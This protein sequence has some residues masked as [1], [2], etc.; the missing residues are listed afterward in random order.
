MRVSDF[1]IDSTSDRNDN[2]GNYKE[3]RD[4]LIPSIVEPDEDSK[5]YRKNWGRLIQKIYE[6][7][8]KT[9]KHLGLVLHALE[10]K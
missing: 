7:I 9:P 6:A 4:A 8:E 3:N 1:Q 5:A 10:H 2:S